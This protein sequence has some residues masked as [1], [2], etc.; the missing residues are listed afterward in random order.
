L[1]GAPKVEGIAALAD[2]GDWLLSLVTDPDDPSQ[3]SA[4]LQVRLGQACE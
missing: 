2:G 4:L 3:A 1:Q